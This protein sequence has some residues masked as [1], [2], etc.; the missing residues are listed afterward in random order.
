VAVS[1]IRGLD[2]IDGRFEADTRHV[3]VANSSNLANGVP[4]ML[5]KL[6]TAST[7][8]KARTGSGMHDGFKTFPD[9]I[10]LRSTGELY[11]GAKIAG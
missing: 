9:N 6:G 5:I 10:L 1:L 7:T 2:R 8:T 4:T 3:A 11:M